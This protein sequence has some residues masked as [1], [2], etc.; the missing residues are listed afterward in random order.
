MFEATMELSPVKGTYVRE[1]TS[2]LAF[3]GVV[4]MIALLIYYLVELVF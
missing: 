3:G 4:V 1:R 2:I